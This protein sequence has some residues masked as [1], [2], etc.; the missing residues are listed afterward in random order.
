M[1]GPDDPLTARRAREA[2][3]LRDNLHRRKVQL[4]ARQDAATPTGVHRSMAVMS[5]RW[6][7]IGRAS[8]RERV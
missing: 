4:R 6:I 5:D 8:C 2:A 7:Q 1:S 3:R